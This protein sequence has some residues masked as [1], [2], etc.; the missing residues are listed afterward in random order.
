MWADTLLT[1]ERGHLERLAIWGGGCLLL[2]TLLVAWLTWRQTTAPLLRHFA[3]QTAAWGAIDL[4]ICA[5]SWRGLALRNY[6]AAQE[7]VSFLWLN[8]GLDV[9]YALVGATLAITCWRLGP[10]PAGIGAGI[11]IILQGL[12]L[13]LLDVRL[14]ALIG[15]LQ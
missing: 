14:V 5:W 9:G 6:A 3:I 11:G 4:A 15:P 13:L 7:L 10:R 8:I 1:L 12:V 2:G